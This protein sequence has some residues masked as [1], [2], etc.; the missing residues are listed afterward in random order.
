MTIKDTGIGVPD[1]INFQ[2]STSLGLKLVK[3][4]SE[5]LGGKVELLRG[6][7]SE[8]RISFKQADYLHRT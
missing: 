1:D 8:F 6:K 5:Q 3:I 4:L 2:K 7:G